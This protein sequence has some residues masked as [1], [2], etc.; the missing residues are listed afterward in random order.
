MIPNIQRKIKR[1]YIIKKR[2]KASGI[3]RKERKETQNVFV[4]NGKTFGNVHGHLDHRTI[5]M[6]IKTMEVKFYFNIK[7][8]NNNNNKNNNNFYLLGFTTT[9]IGDKKSTVVL[10]KDFL[11]FLLGSFIDVL[12]V[13]SNDGLS[14][15]LTDSIDLGDNTYFNSFKY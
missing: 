9:G 5:K 15:S 7:Y 11:D 13:E 10:D 2:K 3:I 4:F 8:N 14:K 1:F 12:L 6:I